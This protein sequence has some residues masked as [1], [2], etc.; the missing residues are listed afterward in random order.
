MNLKDFL[1]YYFKQ[2]NIEARRVFMTFQSYIVALAVFP[3]TLWRFYQGD[4]AHGVADILIILVLLFFGQI[5]KS[6]SKISYFAWLFSSFYIIITLYILNIT[7]KDILFWAF[8]AAI[9]MHFLL[10]SN[11]AL[12]MNF[13]LLAGIFLSPLN[14]SNYAFISFVFTY[15]ITIILTAQFSSRLKSDNRS[16]QNLTELDDLTQ[17]G[18]RRALDK[19]IAQIVLS[20][21]PEKPQC[22]MILDIDHFKSLNDQFGHQAGDLALKRLATM[23]QRVCCLSIPIYRYGGE[24]FVILIQASLQKAGFIA[25]DLKETVSTSRLIREQFLTISIGIAEL[26]PT[27]QA[28][29][30]IKKADQ[31]LYEAKN[32]GRNQVISYQPPAFP[33]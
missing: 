17:V 27:D 3:F 4:Y 13:V 31:A 20:Y 19:K 32:N 23:I 24:E 18:N 30:W 10:R 7:G 2:D 26:S 5:A 25:E 8:P 21:A 33:D 28:S 1:D 29:E 22:L 6:C 16:L 11:Q 15:L 14:I 12:I 9:S